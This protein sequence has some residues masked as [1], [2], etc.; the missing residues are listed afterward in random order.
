MSFGIPKN[1]Q[2][3]PVPGTLKIPR[4]SMNL[5]RYHSK[6]KVTTHMCHRVSL[7]YRTHALVS[8]SLKLYK[9]HSRQ[10]RVHSSTS[11][12]LVAIQFQAQSQT[13]LK[14]GT[15]PASLTGC[16]PGFCCARETT[17]YQASIS[18]RVLCLTL[19]FQ[20]R[21]WIRECLQAFRAGIW[22]SEGRGKI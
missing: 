16:H 20:G 18:L 7:L 2:G 11:S 14:D 8:S 4:D 5:K 15:L 12:C 13:R 22:K 3:S 9:Y 17:T 19:T 10:L 6:L 21:S 1:L